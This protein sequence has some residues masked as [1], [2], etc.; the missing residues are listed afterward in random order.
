ME[1]HPGTDFENCLYIDPTQLGMLRLATPVFG[2]SNI[3]NFN[4]YK[5]PHFLNL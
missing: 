1:V 4:H 5:M 3:S 2:I